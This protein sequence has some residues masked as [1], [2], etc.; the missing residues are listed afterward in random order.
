M[1][2]KQPDSVKELRDFL[3]DEKAKVPEEIV[4]YGDKQFL[5]TGKTVKDSETALESESY[6]MNLLISCIRDPDTRELLFSKEDI[7]QLKEMPAQ[8]DGW[9]TQLLDACLRVNGVSKT[10]ED[11]VEELKKNPSDSNSG[12]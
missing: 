8:P 10:V 5:V 7:P 1:S 3:L 11:A 12:D 4:E 9:V 2:K 6:V